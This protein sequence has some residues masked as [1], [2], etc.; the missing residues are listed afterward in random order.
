MRVLLSAIGVGREGDKQRILIV[1]DDVDG[2]EMYAEY[3]SFAGFEVSTARDGKEAIEKA[4]TEH[5]DVVVMD[6]PLPLV[7][8]ISATR[9]RRR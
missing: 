3:L 2:R 9:T 7:D 6:L 5:P 8:G 4:Q 1:D